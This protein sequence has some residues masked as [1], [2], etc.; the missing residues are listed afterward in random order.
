MFRVSSLLCRQLLSLLLILCCALL[1][2][3]K[4]GSSL[5]PGDNAP[6]FT[7][8]S[9]S[10]SEVSLIDFKGRVVLLNFWASWCMPCIAELPALERLSQRLGPKGL[11]VIAI[12][13][14]DDIAK[15][16]E[17]RDRF[18]LSFPVLFD[19]NSDVKNRYKVSAVPETFIID[20]AGKLKIFLDPQDQMP[21]VR[22][23]G[24][25]EWDSPEM[26]TRLEKLLN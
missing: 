10:S 9:L 7:L 14:D 15:L 18:A 24:P 4:G 20:K 21:V 6:D 13:I 16:S 19:H 5:A 22:I 8:K 12:G 23:I 1:L 17:F 25:R 11:S 26:L 2:A 3:C